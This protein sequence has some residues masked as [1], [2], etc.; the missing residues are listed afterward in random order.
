MKETIRIGLIASFIGIAITAAIALIAPTYFPE[1][2]EI[3][4]HWGPSGAADRFAPASEA[5]RYLW[6]MPGALIFAAALLSIMPVLEPLRANLEQSRKAYLAVWVSVTVLLTL[7]Q[8]G[9]AFGMSQPAEDG[10]EIVRLVIAASSMMF[11]I[12]GNY[13]PKTRQSFTLGIRTPWTLTSQTS[14]A[15]THKLG[16]V[17]FIAAG[18]ISLAAA[19]FLDGIILAFIL[20]VLLIS[21]LAVLM[22]YSYLVWKRADDKTSAPDYLV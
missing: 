16:G 10:P 3:P 1:G 21:I 20:P 7:I 15:R 8:A 4:V 11:I 2:A 22:T 13:L 18:C 14:W 6:L 12:L 5:S 17:L 19:F 9:I